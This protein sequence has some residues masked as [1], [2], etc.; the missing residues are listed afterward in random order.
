MRRMPS[1]SSRRAAAGPMPG[2]S[3]SSAHKKDHTEQAGARVRADR[4][5][6]L[7]GD[8]AAAGVAGRDSVVKGPRLLG[9]PRMNDRTEVCP[10]RRREFDGALEEPKARFR[11]ASNSLE[12]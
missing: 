2:M 9:R 10:L 5:P 6:R 7:A 8:Q 1:L 12:R 3:R 11:L 4:R